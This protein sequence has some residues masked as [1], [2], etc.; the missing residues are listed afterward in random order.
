MTPQSYE[1]KMVQKT[2]NLLSA[3]MAY[4]VDLLE[5]AMKGAR[6]PPKQ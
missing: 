4:W 6:R 5:A 3:A 1:K 2:K